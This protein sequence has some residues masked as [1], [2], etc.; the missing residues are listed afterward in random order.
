MSSISWE[1]IQHLFHQALEY[2]PEARASFV[3]GA[4]GGEPALAGEVAALLAAHE[5]TGDLTSLPSAWLGAVGAPERSRFTP[6]ERWGQF[7]LLEKVGAGAT[8]EVWRAWD[9]TLHREVAIKFIKERGEEGRSEPALLEEARALAGVRHP[10]VVTVFGM[11]EIDGRAGLWMELLRGATLAAAIERRGALP[12]PEVAHIGVQLCGALEALDRA[13]LVH[14]DIKPANVVLETDQ[15]AVLTDFGL[16]WRRRLFT[17]DEP[18]PGAGTPVFMA[19][20]LLA[21]GAP[22]PRT[23]LYALGV[24]LRWVLTGRAPFDAG[25]FEELKELTS[26][27]PR[28]SLLSER[29]DAPAGLIEAIECAMSVTSEASPFTAAQLRVRLQ[30]VLDDSGRAE[31]SSLAE[32]P[33]GSRSVRPSVGVLPFLNHGLDESDDY[34]SEGLA[35]ELITVLSKIRNLHVAARTSSFQFRGK[36]EDLTVIGQKLQVATILEGSVRKS[37]NRVRIAV[38]LVNVREG[39]TIWSEQYDRTLDDIFAVQDDITRAVVR[40]LQV[41]LMG[42]TSMLEAD[43]TIAVRGR[44]RSAEAHRLYLH[45]RYLAG[46]GTREDIE[47]GI[48]RMHEALRVEPD[49]AL[50][51]AWLVRAYLNQVGMLWMS[52]AEGIQKAKEAADRALALQPDLPEGH[53]AAA[54]IRMRHSWDWLGAEVSLLRAVELSPGSS[55]CLRAAG[56]LARNLGRADTAIEFTRRAAELDPLAP[57]AYVSLALSYRAANRL[58]EGE[59]AFRKA[60]ELAPNRTVLRSQLALLLLEQGRHDEALKQ[61]RMESHEALRLLALAII[62][63]AAGQRD[64]SDRALR[65]LIDG[66]SEGAA[67]QIAEVYAGRGEIDLAFDW[68]ERAYERHDTGLAALLGEPQ[69]RSLHGDPRWEAFLLKMGLGKR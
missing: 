5:R 33:R 34:F 9:E 40:E 30:A 64:E 25:T 46:S 31:T 27:G 20:S 23:D 49:H 48:E 65:R 11:G 44:G 43:L 57:T 32:G 7:A 3:D 21:G 14:R 1:R 28:R 8:G 54:L 60:L 26:K 39:H 42:P 61:A 2:P 67:F 19:P 12:W 18:H 50:A 16:G 66:F 29:P 63:Y 38:R 52:T 10:S 6:G 47:S 13:G 59:A 35:E 45:A 4:C 55:D 17:S 36:N 58:A 15:R 37:G 68:L 51:W 24:T 41:T 53:T 22:T 69:F 56:S 62:H